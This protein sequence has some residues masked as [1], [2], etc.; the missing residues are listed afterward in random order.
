[1]KQGE[2]EGIYRLEQKC[3]EHYD[4]GYVDGYEGGLST[5]E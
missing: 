2:S 3:Q 4:K 5:E 1:M